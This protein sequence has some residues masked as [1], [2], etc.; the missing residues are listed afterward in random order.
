MPQADPTQQ[1]YRMCNDAQR[2]IAAKDAAFL[3]MIN[4]PDNPMTNADLK[5]LI[6]RHPGRY[7]KYRAYLGK[8]KD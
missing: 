8:L 6:D 2:R 1:Q 7:G 4:D 5:L 3:E